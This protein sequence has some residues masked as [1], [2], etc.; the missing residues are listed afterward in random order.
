VPR[1]RQLVEQGIPRGEQVLF[2]FGRPG[3]MA[4]VRWGLRI[5]PEGAKK[6][7]ARIDS[8]FGEVESRLARGR[9]YLVGDRLTAADLTF[10]A[11]AGP[12][13]LPPEY[14]WPLPSIEDGPPELRDLRDR[15]RSRPAGNFALRLYKEERHRSAIPLAAGA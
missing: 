2:R 1:L 11:L 10:A 13:L 12:V 15:L 3:I 8:V 4:F 14:G 7:E 9:G 5:G 6:S